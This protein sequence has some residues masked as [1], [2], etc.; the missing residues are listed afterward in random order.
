MN[1]WMTT[2]WPSNDGEDLDNYIPEG[3][4]LP[5]GRQTAEDELG[6]GERVLAYQSKTGRPE[7]KNI[8]GKR[9]IYR[10]TQG[11]GGIIAITEV[12]GDLQARQTSAPSKYTFGKDI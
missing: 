12:T 9:L 10:P 3:V 5:D 4:W 1:Y 8:K 2:F 11:K 6:I 7:I